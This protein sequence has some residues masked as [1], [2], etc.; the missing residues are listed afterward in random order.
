MNNTVTFIKTIATF[1]TK[2]TFSNTSN[3]N[4]TLDDDKITET[5]QKIKKR[6]V[7]IELEKVL[8]IKETK[9][10]INKQYNDIQR[11]R[12]FLKITNKN[13]NS[14]I[15]TYYLII[16]HILHISH[17]IILTKYRLQEKLFLI[18]R[19]SDSLPE[20]IISNVIHTENLSHNTVIEKDHNDMILTNKET[21]SIINALNSFVPD[22]HP[23]LTIPLATNLHPILLEFY[24]IVLNNS[25]I[26]KTPNDI[27]SR[28]SWIILNL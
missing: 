22:T 1:R 17:V 23:V 19:T 4:I 5:E 25:Y 21:T 16:Y 12:S 24:Y 11:T 27:L 15:E 26:S 6:L 18:Y 2:Q 14:N 28:M 9:T 20:Y 3:I 7:N 10:I 8:P 13:S